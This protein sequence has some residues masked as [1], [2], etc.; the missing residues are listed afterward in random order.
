MATFPKDQITRCVIPPEYQE[1][2]ATMY[3]VHTSDG[4]KVY[5]YVTKEANKSLLAM[6]LLQPDMYLVT[7]LKSIWEDA[8]QEVKTDME[9]FTKDFFEPV[10]DTSE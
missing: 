10:P 7:P 9:T 2:I 5:A 6:A 1:Q 4:V 3:V 8:I